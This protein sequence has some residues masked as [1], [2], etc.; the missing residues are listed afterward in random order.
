MSLDAT[1][2]ALEGQ[3]KDPESS[4]LKAVMMFDASVKS[5]EIMRFNHHE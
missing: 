1:I 2:W 3:F 5:I 4:N